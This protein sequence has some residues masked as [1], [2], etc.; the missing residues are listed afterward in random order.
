MAATDRVNQDVASASIKDAKSHIL[1]VAP[2]AGIFADGWKVTAVAIE[3]DK[4]IKSSTISASDYKVITGVEGQKITRVYTNSKAEKTT[5]VLEGRY[6]ILELSHDYRADTAAAIETGKI[7]AVVPKGNGVAP[8]PI[9]KVGNISWEPSAHPATLLAQDQGGNGKVVYV[10][11]VGDI[12][13]TSGDRYTVLKKGTVVPSG[14]SDDTV[15]NHAYTWQ[16]GYSIKGL[17]D[18]LFTQKK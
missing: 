17:R 15:N 1:G 13:T 16:T 4:T 12:D 6:V 14:V 11:Q 3:Y 2:I 8:D 9:E 10:Y 5:Q 7:Q 18:W